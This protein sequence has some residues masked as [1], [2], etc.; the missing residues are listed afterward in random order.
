MLFQIYEEGFQMNGDSGC[1][2]YV[3]EAEG[4]SFLDA[5]KNY[6]K[7][8]KRGEIRKGT[9]GEKYACDWGCKWYPSELQA[10]ETFG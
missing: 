7:K 3:G 5:C 1:A 6:I 9:N 10:R 2:S 8:N 4:E